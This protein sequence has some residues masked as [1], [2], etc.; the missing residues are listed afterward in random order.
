MRFLSVNI[1][2]KIVTAKDAKDAKRKTE[3]SGPSPGTPGE[4]R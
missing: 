1:L 2:E 3:L 4:A